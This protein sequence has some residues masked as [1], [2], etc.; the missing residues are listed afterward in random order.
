VKKLTFYRLI[1]S[2]Y[3]KRLRQKIHSRSDSSSGV[4]TR[5]F[6]KKRR[7]AL[8]I[9]LV[10]GAFLVLILAVS[11]FTS[12]STGE[13]SEGLIGTYTDENLPGYVT[14]LISKP[15]ITLDKTGKVTPMA[16]ASWSANPETNMYT[17]ILRDDLRWSDGTP[18]KASELQFNLPDV[19]VTYPN[20][21]TIVFKLAD[22]YSPFP[23]L[24]TEPLLK[25]GRLIGLGTYKVK[26]AQYQKKKLL[27]LRLVTDDKNLPTVVIRFYQD[28]K[29]AKTAF[30]LG[31]IESLIGVIDNTDVPASDLVNTWDIPNFNKIVGVFFNTKDPILSDDNFR[32]GLMYATQKIE[33]EQMAHGPISPFSWAFNSE[34]KE[35]LDNPDLAKRNL[36]K[37]TNGKD[38][39]INLTVSPQLSQLGNR[40]V[41]NWKKY[42]INAVT[43]VESGV[44]QNF[45]A[46]LMSETIPLDP[47]Q[48]S[49]WHSTQ[50]K[51]NLSQYQS[52]RVDRDLEE[53]RKSSDPKLRLERYHDFQ[54]VMVD[55]APAIFLYF[56]KLKVVYLK[57][58]E[59][60]L[61]KIIGTQIPTL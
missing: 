6:Y 54:R 51:T 31:E 19:T 15:L 60:N 16:A 35:S 12:R 50:V 58:S 41:E 18:V 3:F 23:T 55:D 24:L 52:K 59:Q 61:Q 47:D 7:F 34:L 21:K 49:L 48:Y 46:A 22:S 33:G 29:T 28:E 56:P 27:K 9:P 13:V 57:R 37:V 5:T 2:V 26:D 20:D 53:G 38:T 11:Y 1:L 4:D 32:R 17:F 36:D 40:I 25:N 43:R 39:Q 30:A 14:N 10:I 42:G 45:Q 8:G 44:P